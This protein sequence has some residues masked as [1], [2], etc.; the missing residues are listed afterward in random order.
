MDK[1]VLAALWAATEEDLRWVLTQVTLPAEK[2][3]LLDE[4][5]DHNELGLARELLIEA[6]TDPPPAIAERL[7]QARIR[8]GFP[9][10]SS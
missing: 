10:T 6:V 4:F 7:D 8:M 5:L 9:P 2:L 1:Q 3:D